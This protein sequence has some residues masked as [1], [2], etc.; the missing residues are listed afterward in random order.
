METCAAVHGPLS[1]PRR[2]SWFGRRLTYFAGILRTAS[3]TGAD[4]KI[5]D[6][7]A[8]VWSRLHS[9]GARHRA[10]AGGLRVKG[11]LDQRQFVPGLSFCRTAEEEQRGIGGQDEPAPAIPRFLV[12]VAQFHLAPIEIDGADDRAVPGA[13]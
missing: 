7:E 1:L 6:D 9:S 10:F 3:C 8:P 12:R 11:Q 2:R 5:V 4:G 13:A